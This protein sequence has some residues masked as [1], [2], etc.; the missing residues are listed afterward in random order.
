MLELERYE[1]HEEHIPSR[2]KF[3]IAQYDKE[4]IIVYQAFKPEIAA[5]AV[6]HQRFGGA[7][8]DFERRTWIKPSFLW[9]MHYSGWAQ[10][11]NQENVLAIRMRRSGFDE[12]LTKSTLWVSEQHEV[13]EQNIEAYLSWEHYYDLLGKKT[14]RFAAK[15][16]LKGD[17][18]RQYNEEWILAIE[19]ISD[20]VREQQQMLKTD[21]RSNLRLPHER[22]Y[23]PANLTVL[24]RI[25]ATSI[26]L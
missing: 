13:P 26:S 16:G 7:E 11:Q 21:Q 2:G 1:E 9:M 22:A 24:Q 15:I 14:D 12:L 25:E 8:Y 17:L 19:N 6:A 10:K 18:L 5:W 23:A 20:Y 4:S 3:I